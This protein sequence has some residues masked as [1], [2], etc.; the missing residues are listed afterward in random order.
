MNIALI[1]DKKYGLLQIRNA[2]PK[3]VSI[4]YFS[5]AKDFF[6]SQKKY[7]I[8][9]L[10]YYLD[11]DGITGDTVVTNV[12]EKADIIVGF[13]SVK[14]GNEKLKKAGAQYAVVKELGERN[15]GIENLVFELG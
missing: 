7:H 12:L 15:E 10:D 13:S 11:K 9:F 1:D 6:R 3:N 14:S 8:V 4:D 5:R 2:F